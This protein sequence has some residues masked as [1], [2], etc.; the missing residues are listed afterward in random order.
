MNVDGNVAGVM[1][2]L[3]RRADAGF[4]KYG[5]T[6]ERTDISL[7]GWLQH[8]QEELMDASVY[9]ER[10]KK[11]LNVQTENNSGQSAQV[12]ESIL[13]YLRTSTSSAA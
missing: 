6:T 9:V 5:T 1:F 2:Q 3:A 7:T 12:F 8:L 4:A 11:E 13:P 10:I